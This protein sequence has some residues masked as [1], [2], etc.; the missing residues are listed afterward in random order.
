MHWY[1][2]Y[3]VPLLQRGVYIN[4]NSDP[5]ILILLDKRLIKNGLQ[6][7]CHNCSQTQI[8]SSIY[9]E[10]RNNQGN[11]DV[12]LFSRGDCAFCGEINTFY[13]LAS[14]FSLFANIYMQFL[15]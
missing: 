14:L 1:K 13:N 3:T 8:L 7:K 6:R 15:F 4:L 2:E 9:T 5:H 12:T 11:V 10:I